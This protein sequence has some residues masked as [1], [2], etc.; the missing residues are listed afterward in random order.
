MRSVLI[1]LAAVGLCAGSMAHAAPKGPIVAT[2]A[3]PWVMDYAEDSCRLAR[4]FESGDASLFFY[5]ERFAPSSSQFVLVAGKPLDR[6]RGKS[7][8]LRFSPDGPISD[9]LVFWGKHGEF[10]PALIAPAVWLVEK[11]ED[12]DEDLTALGPFSQRVSP[13]RE[14]AIDALEVV[15]SKRPAV[16]L[17]LG[18]MGPAFKAMR[19]CT[20]ELVTHWGLD[21]EAHRRLTRA[22]A[23][24]GNPGKWVSSAD[25]PSDAIRKG[26]Q[27][28]IPFRLIIGDD[29]VPTD[30]RLQRPTEPAEFNDVVCRILMKRARFEPALDAAGKPIKSYWSSTFNFLMG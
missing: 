18:S 8:G 24:K 5:I 4:K 21:V 2:P 22:P 3:G 12:E 20:D 28:V 27:G 1:R 13:D 9:K 30:C 26:A 17:A 25:Y 16:K 23:P 15:A 10:D 29:G 14:K 11:P 6:L 19:K 7:V